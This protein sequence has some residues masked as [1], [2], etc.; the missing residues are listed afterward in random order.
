MDIV[1]GIIQEIF[2]EGEGEHCD[3]KYAAAEQGGEVAGKEKGVGTGKVNIKLPG[4][5]TLEKS[6]K[7]DKDAF[8][9]AWKSS[10][11]NISKLA[12]MLDVSRVTLYRYLKKYDLTPK[13]EK[14]N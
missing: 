7:Y 10:G 13:T 4:D 6:W 1:F 3:L 8:I 9:A 11:G 12:G 14:N 5:K 2:S